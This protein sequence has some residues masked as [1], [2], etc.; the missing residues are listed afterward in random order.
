LPIRR[1]N[2]AAH[3]SA[4]DSEED[5]K[6]MPA[7]LFMFLLVLPAMAQEGYKSMECKKFARAEGVELSPEFPDFLTAAVKA[8][9]K[10]AKLIKEILS[11]G[12]VVD[13]ADQAQSIVIEGTLLQ[14]K[15]GSA[16]K[17]SLIGFGAGRRSLTA[18]VT[19]RRR[20]NQESL[21][22]RTLVVKTSSRMK[23]D[24]LARSLAKKMVNE[25]KTALKLKKV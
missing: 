24:L 3:E 9:F 16:I 8:E 22:D 25:I 4:N 1:Y 17:E 19:V 10:K 15:R 20:S 23:E 12:E 5:M 14:F 13:S 7:F 21:F 2:G 11:E 18:Q 6:R